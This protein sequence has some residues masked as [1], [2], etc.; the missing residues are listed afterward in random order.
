[1]SWSPDHIL[2]DMGYSGEDKELL[3]DAVF[4]FDR[5]CENDTGNITAQKYAESCFKYLPERLHKD[6]E[7]IM[8][9]WYEHMPAVP[10][11]ADLIVKLRSEG[12]GIYFLSNISVEFS[13]NAKI[14]PPRELFDG[15][16]FSGVEKVL[17]PHPEIYR[18]LLSRYGLKAEDCIFIDDRLDNIEGA[19][20]CGIKG[21]LFDGDAG[22]LAE[23][24]KNF[25][26]DAI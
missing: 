22:K 14:V 26:G 19:E 20:S 1:M 6:A 5:W 21:Y 10:G 9:E 16:V 2:S 8:D 11:M 25:K 7:R 24:L 3:L 18:L 12:Y 17:K 13:E 15:M 4:T 23:Y